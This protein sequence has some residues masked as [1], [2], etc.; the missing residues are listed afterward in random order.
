MRIDHFRGFEAYYAIPFGSKDATKGEWRKGP[1]KEF[2][3]IIK[4]SVGS[5]PFIAEDLGIITK[6]VENLRDSIG[7]PG[8]RVLQFA[9]DDS[10]NNAY[11][12]H[13]H[14][15]NCNV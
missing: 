7:L 9:F 1:G 13:N 4:K 5:L 14:I 8:M 3:D 11:L 12:P 6:E 15:K 10:E 2:F